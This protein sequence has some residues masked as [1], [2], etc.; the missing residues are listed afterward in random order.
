MHCKVTKKK[1]KT[2]MS[3]GKMPMANGFLQKKDFKKE[4][5]YNLQVGFNEKNYLFQVGNHPK[6]SRIFNNKYPF[7]TH[8]SK[9]MINH[10]KSFFNWLDKN[11]LK[12]N[13]KIIEIGS[14]DG[15]FSSYFKKKKYDILGFEPSLNVAKI[16][17]KKGLKV[18]SKFF[19]Y[20][21]VFK[22][23]KLKN[24]INLICAANVICHIPNL[25]NLIK[26]IDYLLA[27]D[28]LFIFEEPYLGSMFNKVSYDQIYDAHV[29]IFSLHSVKTI[30]NNFGFELINAVPQTTHG[31][32]M[33]YVIARKKVFKVMNSVKNLLVK[34]KIN[35]LHKLSSCIK[36]KKNCQLSKKKFRFKILNLIK[37]GKRICG[38][39]ASAKS[40]TALNYCGID[41]NY[42][43]FI[44][45]ST[46]EKIGKFTPGTHIPIKS[47]DYFRKNYPDIT[48][49]NSWNHKKEILKKEHQFKKKGG[50]WIS[51][52]K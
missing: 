19:N 32:S 40:T 24:Q 3:F 47:P 7:F 36:F 33:R 8:K 26:S 21:N 1:I 15:T 23:K 34:E 49:L 27:K 35:K 22:Y 48:I 2:I 10:F 45:D 43:D 12:K 51:H 29:F 17:R 6:S 41:H 42:I 28:G 16:A 46:K 37:K 38:Y 4:F 18:S 13:H 30:F 11:Y 44:V 52:V 9:L 25:K 31:G 50:K 39:A 20:E 5:F 14:N